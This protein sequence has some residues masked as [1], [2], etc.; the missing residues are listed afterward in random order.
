MPTD[1]I[2]G[3][4]DMLP[5]PPAA[6]ITGPLDILP[7]ATGPLDIATAALTRPLDM[8]PL[9]PAAALR[10]PLDMPAACI[11]ATVLPPD[12]AIAIAAAELPP[13]EMAVETRCCWSQRLPRS[14]PRPPPP[15]S[16]VLPRRPAFATASA[17]A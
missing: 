17:A 14:P 15:P 11:T 3:P 10:G 5:L 7:P 6:C 4:L 9:P 16:L 2:D 8:L 1:A 12:A 13:M